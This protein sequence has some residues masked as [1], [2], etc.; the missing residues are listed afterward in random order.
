M[1][2]NHDHLKKLD[3]ED[4]VTGIVLPLLFG[5]MINKNETNDVQNVQSE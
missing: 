5:S 3:H 4:D 2:S 1:R